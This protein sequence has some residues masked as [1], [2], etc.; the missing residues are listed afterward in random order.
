MPIVTQEEQFTRPEEPMEYWIEAFKAQAEKLGLQYVAGYDENMI[1]EYP[2]IHIMSGTMSKEVHGTH[3]YLFTFRQPIY[4]MHAKADKDRKQRNLEDLLLATGVVN[5]IESDKKLG[6]KV[7]FSY[8]EEESPGILAPA[9][10][11]RSRG[12][13]IV[14]TRLTWFATSEGR[15]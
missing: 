11:G 15:F 2:S 10:G 4:V 6:G 12:D 14:G 1:P 9:R 7:I 5:F 8:V 13:L 3:T